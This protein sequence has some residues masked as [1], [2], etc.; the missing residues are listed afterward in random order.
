MTTRLFEGLRT[1]PHFDLDLDTTDQVPTAVTDW[2]RALAQADGVLVASPEYGHSLP[3]SLK[4]A[5]DWV[6]GSGQLHHKPMILTAAVRDPGRGHRG[7][8][9]LRQTLLALD[10][11]VLRHDPIVVGGSDRDDTGDPDESETARVDTAL[12]ERLEQLAAAVQ[13]PHGASP[14]PAPPEWAAALLEGT[15]LEG[16]LDLQP[17]GGG[18]VPQHDAHRLGANLG[19]ALSTLPVGELAELAQRV[20]RLL[21]HP[22]HVTRGVARDHLLP[23]TIAAI[24]GTAMLQP[25]VEALGPLCVAELE[26]D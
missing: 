3:G 9:A 4:N 19:L 14:L 5:I 26:R 12:V 21:A 10:A 7:L 11:V 8:R 22:D 17:T 18:N 2:R 1:L 25:W 20:E 6:F 23:A 16:C 24:D 13:H 15:S